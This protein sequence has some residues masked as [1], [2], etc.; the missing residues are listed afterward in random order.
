MAAER[1]WSVEIVVESA[2]GGE[3]SLYYSYHCKTCDATSLFEINHGQ[4]ILR[5]IYCVRKHIVAIEEADVIGISVQLFG[6]SGVDNDLIDF[7]KEHND[8]EMDL[9]AENGEIEPIESPGK[10]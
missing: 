10:N 5:K 7:L 6:H 4:S 1:A 2:S 3:M 9:I 8:H